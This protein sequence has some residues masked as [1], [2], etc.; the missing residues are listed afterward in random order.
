MIL[1]TM[2]SDEDR[3]RKGYRPLRDLAVSSSVFRRGRRWEFVVPAEQLLAERRMLVNFRI[4]ICH[5]AKE[6]Q[7]KTPLLSM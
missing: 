5:S 6:L 4:A 3:K 1:S 7:L 2:Q